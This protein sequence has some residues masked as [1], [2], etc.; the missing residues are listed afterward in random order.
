MT[1]NT[2]DT[3]SLSTR[4]HKEKAGIAYRPIFRKIFIKKIISFV[5]KY[6]HR[7]NECAHCST[8]QLLRNSGYDRH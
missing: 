7:Y 5:E 8:G 3:W 4:S 1:A 2:E 6:I